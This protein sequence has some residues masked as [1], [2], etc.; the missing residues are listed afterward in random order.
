MTVVTTMMRDASGLKHATKLYPR[1]ILIHALRISVCCLSRRHRCYCNRVL[2]LHVSPPP[3]DRS[4]MKPGE[5]PLKVGQCVEWEGGYNGL[6]RFL[7]GTKAKSRVT[8]TDG[9]GTY[10]GPD[11]VEVR[12][13]HRQDVSAMYQNNN[14]ICQPCL[15]D[16]HISSL[17]GRRAISF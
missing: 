2:C 15:K 17:R 9:G 6:L 14:G 10:R 3:C 1:Y 12:P 5:A 16:I 11:G 7:P 8:V 4:G 13:N